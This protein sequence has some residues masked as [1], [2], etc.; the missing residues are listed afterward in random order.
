MPGPSRHPTQVFK[1]RTGVVSVAYFPDGQRIASASINKTVIISNVKSGRQ[2]GKPLDH[3]AEIWWIAISLDGRRIA[4]ATEGTG[5]II[6]DALTREVVYKIK[7]GC[8]QWQTYSP[9]GRWIATLRV[10]IDRVVQLWDADTGR[11]SGE[12][13]KCDDDVTC[14][15]FSPDGSWIAVGFEDGS[16]QVIDISTGDSVVG[17]IKGHTGCMSSVV[18]LRDGCLL[19]TAAEE[20]SICVWNSGK[21]ENDAGLP[22]LPRH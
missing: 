22:R 1:G 10:D 7:C 8:G 3:S 5:V 16:F 13:L 17:P 6:W 12:A 2:D 20:E 9:D 11:P 14:M 15:A 18:Y 19:V 21:R 4:C